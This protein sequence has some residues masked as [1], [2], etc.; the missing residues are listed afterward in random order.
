MLKLIVTQIV[1][2]IT[3]LFTTACTLIK[4]LLL[5]PVK[6]LHASFIQAFQNAASLKFLYAKTLLSFK[7]LLA[8][9]ITLAQ[10]I[11]AGLKH[12]V[13]TSGQTGSQPQTTAPKTRQRVKAASKKGK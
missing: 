3:A 5:K 7:V 12:V 1:G 6:L 13:T 9:C 11:K 10:S 8:Q 4:G 2:Q